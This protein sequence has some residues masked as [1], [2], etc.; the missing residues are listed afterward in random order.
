MKAVTNVADH[1]RHVVREEI[2]I[3]KFLLVNLATSARMIWLRGKIMNQQK[4]LPCGY[5]AKKKKKTRQEQI[6]SGFSMWRL[7]LPSDL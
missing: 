3:C 6:R 5:I 2:L 7:K 4:V 1:E